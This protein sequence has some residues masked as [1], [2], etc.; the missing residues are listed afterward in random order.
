[1]SREERPMVKHVSAVIVV[2]E[3]AGAVAAFYR[4]KLGIPLQDEQHAGGGEVLHYGCNLA[5]LH[6]AV[7]PVQNWAHADAVG[8]GGFRVAFRIDDAEASA[9]K[10]RR[11]GQPFQGPVDEGWA[12]MIQLRDPDGNYVELVERT[13]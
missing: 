4:D 6:F 2:S 7:H 13:G 9:S 8:P 5:G 10:L 11:F 1:M 3:N 12:K